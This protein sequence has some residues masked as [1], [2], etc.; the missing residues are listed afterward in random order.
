MK[1]FIINRHNFCRFLKIATF[2]TSLMVS[3]NVFGQG[4][5]AWTRYTYSAV[6]SQGG[7]SSNTCYLPRTETCMNYSVGGN[8]S[9]GTS[10]GAGINVMVSPSST[11][12]WGG[13]SSTTC[14]DRRCDG[15]YYTKTCYQNGYECSTYC[16]QTNTQTC[17]ACP[18]GGG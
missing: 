7:S 17:H 6:V 10:S 8:V 11:K 3:F 15:N 4:T 9:W 14:R 1:R 16:H 2:T 18:P 5:Y 12:C 13:G